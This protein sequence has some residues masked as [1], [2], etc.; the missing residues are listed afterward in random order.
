MTRTT[1]STVSWCFPRVLS[2]V[3]REL[4]MPLGKTNA[5]YQDN[6]LPSRVK[7]RDRGFHAC[8]AHWLRSRL[9]LFCAWRSVLLAQPVPPR[10][11]V[12]CPLAP[13]A[14]GVV[15]HGGVFSRSLSQC[16][17]A[18]C[19]LPTGSARGW[20][21]CGWRSVLC[22]AQPVP[23]RPLVLPTGSARGWRCCAWRSVLLAQP[24]PPYAGNRKGSG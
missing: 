4:L 21:C 14:V 1:T 8:A 19:A 20:C 2:R 15:V 24:V 9:A 11:L 16:H 7:I 3:A 18:H 6:G 17:P 12:C 23:P 13:L 5:Q 22:S 10:P